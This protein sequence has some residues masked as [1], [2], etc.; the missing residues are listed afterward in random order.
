VPPVDEALRFL[1]EH[2]AATESLARRRRWIVGSPPKV[3]AGLEALAEEYGA[4]ARLYLVL[5][6]ASA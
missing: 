5:T 4:R 3:R 2:G 1:E 6:C